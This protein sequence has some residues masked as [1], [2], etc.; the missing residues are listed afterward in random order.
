MKWQRDA[1]STWIDVDV[2]SS[3]VLI[4]GPHSAALDSVD[5]VEIC[6]GLMGSVPDDRVLVGE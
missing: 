4:V 1:C 2:S 3:L 5:S 6:F